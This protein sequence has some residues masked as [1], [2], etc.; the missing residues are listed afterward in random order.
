MR[1]RKCEQTMG[2]R[3]HALLGKFQVISKSFEMAINGSK[4][5]NCNINL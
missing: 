1:T 4:T 2:V 3:G 5:A